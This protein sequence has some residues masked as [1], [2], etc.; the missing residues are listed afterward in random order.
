MGPWSRRVTVVGVQGRATTRI[1]PMHLL[2]EYADTA[3]AGTGNAREGVQL[4][5]SGQDALGNTLVSRHLP[6][7]ATVRHGP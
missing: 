4:H 1:P 7:T 5:A 2:A 3:M 6:G